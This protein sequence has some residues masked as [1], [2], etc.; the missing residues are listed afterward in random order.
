[1]NVLSIQ[2]DVAYGHVGNAAARLALQCLGHEVWALPSV[3]LSSHAG[4][5]NVEGE[6]MPAALLARLVGGLEAN[7]WLAGCDA[8]I[9]GYLGSADQADVVADAVRRVKRANEKALY[10]LDPV[11][12]DDGRAYAKPG[13]AQ[14]MAR[15]LLPLADIVT[16]NAFELSS[17]TGASVRNVSDAL[18]AARR[19]GKNTVLATSIVVGADRLGTLVL[20]DDEAWMASTP[21]LAQVPHGAGDLLAAL[22]VGRLL[23]GHTAE[24]ALELAMRSVFDILQKS[25]GESEMRLIAEQS[26]LADPPKLRDLKIEKAA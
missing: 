9:S 13:V 19:L 25:A 23:I 26:A 15:T 14:A 3:L 5:P 24:G 16:P 2:S 17:L 4:Y 12:G 1:M 7:G 20:H 8:V 10:C 18:A 11:F 6:A 22:F 21:R